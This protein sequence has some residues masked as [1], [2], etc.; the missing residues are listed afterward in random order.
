MFLSTMCA[1]KLNNV[2]NETMFVLSP[3]KLRSCFQLVLIYYDNQA[4]AKQQSKI[5]MGL[6]INDIVVTGYI[7]R[8]HTSHDIFYT[9]G[10]IK[11]M[12]YNSSG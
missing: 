4:V 8:F 1:Y 6:L 11:Y 5:P 2:R 10:M 12:N 9:S 3:I 7:C